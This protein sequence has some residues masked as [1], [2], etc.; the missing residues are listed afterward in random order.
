M[1]GAPFFMVGGLGDSERCDSPV[2][3]ALYLRRL[4]KNW[5][6][7]STRFGNIADTCAGST[8]DMQETFDAS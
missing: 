2:C 7:E 6:A 3:I 4:L 5:H 1:R 8:V